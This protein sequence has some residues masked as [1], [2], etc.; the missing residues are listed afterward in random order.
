MR[1]PSCFLYKAFTLII[2]LL[3]YTPSILAYSN[4]GN[5]SLK[6]SLNT[7]GNTLQIIQEVAD[8]EISTSLLSLKNIEKLEILETIPG[9]KLRLLVVGSEDLEG[10]KNIRTKGSLEIRSK[11][12]LELK[13]DMT[14][15]GAHLRITAPHIDTKANLT[16]P[17]G[18]I[19]IESE[20]KIIFKG[21]ADVSG[22][23][24]GL[25]ELKGRVV[26]ILGNLDADGEYQA[27]QI[28]VEGFN[29]LQAGKVSAD[30]ANGSGGDIDFTFWNRYID[31]Q[32]STVTASSLGKSGG[33][34]RLLGGNTARLFSSGI[35][36]AMGSNEHS[37]GGEIQFLGADLHLEGS[38]LDAS[39][40]S[41]GGRIRVGGDFQGGGT[42]LEAR[43]TSVSAASVLM[44]DARKFGQGGDVVIWS[45][46]VTHFHGK[47]SADSPDKSG[48]VEIS[49]KGELNPGG[50]VT[51]GKLLIDPK[52]ATVD[53]ATGIFPQI[54]L[55]D[56]NPNGTAFGDSIVGLT[57]GNF[58][59]TDP[60][61]DVI[62]TDNG[63]AYLF[64]GSTGALISTLTGAVAADEVGFNGVVALTNGNFVVRSSRWDNG[65]VSN[66]G[67]ATWGDGSTG[68]SGTVSSSNSIVGST[69][70]DSV[71]S[72]GVTALANGNY[73]VRSQSWDNGGLAN[74]GA[75]TFA[76]GTQT[77][78]LVIDDTNSLVGASASS[79][80]S[81]TG[82]TE[83][84]NGNYVVQSTSWDDGGIVNL[85]AVTWAN[86]N[87]GISGEVSTDNSLHGSVA[88]DA[89]GTRVVALSNGN[90]VV[91]ST[92]WDNGGTANVGAVTWGNG[93]MGTTGPVTTDNSLFGSSANDGIG[94]VLTAL[95]NGNYVTA[96]AF[97]D[98]VDGGLA[99]VGAATWG[100]G[101]MG[102]TGE[103]TTTN[104]LHG[105]TAEDR[106]GVEGV[107][108]LTNGNYV[109]LSD[110]WDNGGISNA[111]AATWGDG[112]NG[113]MGISGPVTSTNSLVG[114]MATD[115]I[116]NGGGVALTN[117][118][119]V[120][121]STLWD[122]GGTADVGAVTFGNGTMG[123]TGPVTTDNSLHGSTLTDRI[124]EDGVTALTNG[125]YVVASNLFDDGGTANAGAATWVDGSTG[126]PVGPVTT[127]NSL[128]GSTGDDEVGIGGV[129]A[130]TNGNYVVL[131]PSWDDGGTSDVGAVTFGNGTT[132]ITGPVT[133]TNS[134]HGSTTLDDVGSGGSVTALGNGDYLVV[135]TKFDDPV[136]V[137][138]DAGS[139]TLGDGTNGT[140][141]A[142][143]VANS[144]IGQAATTGLSTIV[145]EDTVN[146]TFALRFETE[147]TNGM[148]RMGCGTAG[149][150]SF[151]C[152]AGSSQTLPSSFLTNLLDQGTDVTL[153]VSNDLTVTSSI[154][155]NNAGGDGGGLTLTAG[156]SVLIN[157]NITTDNGPLTIIG[158]DL[159]AN[160]VV[161]GDRDSGDAV[162]TMNTGTT[163]DT[164]TGALNI[165][166][167]P[168]AGKSNSG[169]GNLA[170]ETIN[171]GAFTVDL[172][173]S[174]TL[175]FVGPVNATSATIDSDDDI[176]FTATADLTTTG[177]IIVRADSDSVNDGPSGGAL[178]M[179][180]G[181]VF[182]AGASTILLSADEAI[183]LGNVT[184]T[185]ATDTAVS[186]TSKSG[187]IVDVAAT[188]DENVSAASGGI[189]ATT[190]GNFGDPA[191]FIE[192]SVN[193]IDFSG[194]GASDFFI[195]PGTT[196]SFDAASSSDSE[197]NAAATVPV[198]LNQVNGTVTFNFALGG[199][200]TAGGTDYTLDAGTFTIPAGS[201]TQNFTIPVVEDT[202]Q[203]NPET[204][205][206]TISN[207]SDN[208]TLGTNTVHTFT[209][210]DNDNAP[211][212]GFGSTT[213][214]GAEFIGA[215]GATVSLTGSSAINTISVDYA[216]TGGT[217]TTG[218]ID[219]TLNSGTLTFDPGET[220]SGIPITLVNDELV[221]DNETLII[222]LSNPVNATLGTNTSLTFTIFDDDTTAE[223]EFDEI[224]SSGNESETVVSI[225]VSINKGSTQ[226][227]TVDFAVTGGTATS[228]G[229]DFTLTPATL[230]FSPN[231]FSQ[232]IP[233]LVIDDGNP[234][235]SET[236][237]ITLSNPVGATLGTN[238]T[239]TYTIQN[240]GDNT[241]T[242]VTEPGE[243]V[244][245]PFWQMD[246]A[247][248]TFIGVSH[249][250]LQAMHS[251][252]GVKAQAI[253]NTGELLDSSLDFTIN[254]GQTQRVFIV[255]SN[256]PFLN[257]ETL[258]DSLFI[259]GDD[260]ASA[261]GQLVFTG[262]ASN[263]EMIL[264]SGG[265]PDI[266]MLSFW[267][268]VVVEATSTGFA[269][270]FVGDII[271]SRALNQPGFS[272]LN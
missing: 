103:V 48:R 189:V 119:Y 122:D 202:I 248:Y 4:Q 240:G 183:A 266:T 164:G 264:G 185:N 260:N 9:S 59:V 142:I 28:H 55:T 201:L 69:A 121:I 94:S 97:W 14:V 96:A 102:T 110:L 101:S 224:T 126:L 144:I 42:L 117:G 47:I 250:S 130:L 269:M 151:A 157:A 5:P 71:S 217:A 255:R 115:S 249:P 23:Q 245:S 188:S 199:T 149:Q 82:V 257:Q 51:A 26:F 232:E 8:L 25:V 39:G 213:G 192:G 32:N 234:E 87:K 268:A 80:V 271:D 270:E 220:A 68:V 30:S 10:L 84:T 104:S 165:E 57:N 198:S 227:I 190:A 33:R 72:T 27:G 150:L 177:P 263:P 251:E 178:A 12:I 159:L 58:V 186:L 153:Q 85:G 138:A 132:G 219:F 60:A 50:T 43:N 129:V 191:N 123:T 22:D 267:G 124:G 83:L 108:A 34:I 141:G 216:V 125:N 265:Y 253:A 134:L 184:T 136:A 99:N 223:I 111:G 235:G 140:F 31:H 148:V 272:G 62:D 37:K 162:I 204:V 161:D 77:T 212:V 35:H 147:G 56:P 113:S 179:A 181:T 160:G 195:V 168:G 70:S 81:S 90:Y 114:T 18:T 106:I 6:Y 105:T 173:C 133:T 3:I 16:A 211:L 208:V 239:H 209:I 230:S 238:S 109:V 210:N 174:S 262:I 76:L 45:K 214:E 254:S 194:V 74:A 154:T 242:I 2:T 107:I 135:S 221:E 236:L 175:A 205:E 166:L 228:G 258:P 244:V 92:A 155:V 15:E 222:T 46:E 24:A 13:S 152:L 116:A 172:Q 19:K 78:G 243:T 127:T 79:F 169:C 137:N 128:T 89:V 120:I 29:I 91:G 63:A 143:S 98:D 7:S 158:N 229:V 252:I 207:P 11:S 193:A 156:R 36:Q 215:T 65:A 112:S 139:I 20:N 197:S 261:H 163:I 75:A 53:D 17:G 233:L 52:D 200:A 231:V 247:A 171:S 187:V 93:T 167:R 170:L 38:Q 44:A 64:N 61:D 95:T 241:F 196:V 40:Q 21:T 145:G 182:N 49:S 203:E 206:I 226:T 237:I 180:E 259:L 73:V 131:S 246:G 225:P 146:D 118:N 256:H 100:D 176:S 88:S 86:G 66:A 54:T 67:A 41:G 218:G 1:N